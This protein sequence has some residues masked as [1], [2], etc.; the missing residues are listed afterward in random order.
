M[1]IT[2]VI[3]YFTQASENFSDK[4]GLCVCHKSAMNLV[5]MCRKNI[6]E[7]SLKRHPIVIN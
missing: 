7:A 1:K 5:Q 4:H 2:R 3:E 6:K